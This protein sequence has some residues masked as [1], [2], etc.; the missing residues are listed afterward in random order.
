MAEASLFE[1]TRAPGDLACAPDQLDV[2]STANLDHSARAAAY[3][4]R[5]PRGFRLE[6]TAARDECGS[7]NTGAFDIRADD[8]RC[9]VEVTVR[10]QLVPMAEPL[11]SEFRSIHPG[12]CLDSN[13]VATPAAVAREAPLW[14]HTIREIWSRRHPIRAIGVGCPCSEYE[15]D[16]SVQFVNANPHRQ[17]SVHSGCERPDEFNWY[18]D[19]NPRYAAHEFG[20]VLGLLDEYPENFWEFLG[21]EDSCNPVTS[22]ASIMWGVWALDE[23]RV[24]PFHYHFFAEWLARTRCCDFE[25]GRI[26]D[27]HESFESF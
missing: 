6:A 4:I 1:V 26:G 27:V 8:D 16:V 19:M 18:I 24:F 11:P 20:H 23:G 10:L 5:D 15:V 13:R 2:R 17:I 7:R 14:A 25:I 12:R 22:T 9:L 21:V 3:V